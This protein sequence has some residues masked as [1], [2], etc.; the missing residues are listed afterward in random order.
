MGGL[1]SLWAKLAYLAALRD[2]SGDY[3]HWGM[4]QKYGREPA[5]EA[6][7]TLHRQVTNQLLRQPTA[8]VWQELTAELREPALT[9][10]DYDG[11]LDKGKELL[12]AGST[13]AAKEHFMLLIHVMQAFRSRSS[14]DRVA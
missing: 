14:T 3:H 10:V 8:E 9:D 7:R 12:P 1:R 6:I 2:E 5:L 13:R 11:L 4:E